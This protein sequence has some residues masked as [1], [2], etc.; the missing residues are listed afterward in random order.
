MPRCWRGRASY[1]P[2]DGA[3]EMTVLHRCCTHS[4][5]WT[6]NTKSTRRQRIT[7]VAR[8]HQKCNGSPA[9][10]VDLSLLVSLRYPACCSVPP[11]QHIISPSLPKLVNRRTW[12]LNIKVRQKTR[13]GVIRTQFRF[14]L[15]LANWQT[16][17]CVH[18]LLSLSAAWP[19]NLK[20]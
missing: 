3:E 12:I 1:W 13:K 18:L 19:G 4:W 20:L 2:M 8:S 9:Q 6:L 7:R 17:A 14:L 16:A 11:A 15:I 10:L 5:G